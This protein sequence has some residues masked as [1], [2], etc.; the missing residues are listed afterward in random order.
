MIATDLITQILGQWSHPGE[1]IY[2]LAAEIF[3]ICRSITGNGVRITLGILQEHIP[4]TVHEVPSGTEVFDWTVPPEWNI[5]DA[6]I[7]NPAGEKIVDFQESNLHVLGYSAPIHAK[8]S[9]DELKPHLITLPDQPDAIPY[10]TSYY[11]KTWGFCL[12]HRVAESLGQGP[13][14]VM[15]DS[16]F[17]DNGSLTYGELLIPGASEQEILISTHICH[18]SLANDNCA[19]IAT[20]CLLAKNLATQSLPMGIRFVFIP[21]TIG[22]ITWLARNEEHAQSHIRH[23]IV[24]SCIGDPAPPAY[25]RSRRMNA[26]I[27]QA[28]EYILES[29]HAGDHAI[30]PFSPYGYDERQYCSP[31]FNLP[32]GLMMRSKYGEFPQY[33]NSQDNLD[34]ISAEAIDDS[35]NILLR[36]LHVLMNNVTLLNRFPKCEPQLGKRGLYSAIGGD[37]DRYQKQMAMLWILNQSDGRH[38]LLDI[39]KTAGIDFNIIAQTARILIDHQLLKPIQPPNP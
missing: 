36:V 28:F 4:L 11:H 21:G 17:N 35:V 18:P 39:A 38:S 23:G 12:S 33:H 2:R 26:A 30:E 25:K 20:A 19:G 5:R 14:E 7:K 32:V 16:D 3:P 34:F 29:T 37:Q 31:G 8:L 10:R 6:Y 9:I 15:I 27:D 22:S 13:F 24:L 1:E